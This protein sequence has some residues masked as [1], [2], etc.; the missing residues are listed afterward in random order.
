M[1]GWLI[2]SVGRNTKISSRFLFFFHFFWQSWNRIG[3]PDRAI[4]HRNAR[5]LFRH[6]PTVVQISFGFCLFFVFFCRC[7]FVSSLVFS[8][9]TFLRRIFVLCFFLRPLTRHFIDTFTWAAVELFF[10]LLKEN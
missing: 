8:S 3:G 9:I 1:L 6:A 5:R 4:G 7:C 10:F 2:E